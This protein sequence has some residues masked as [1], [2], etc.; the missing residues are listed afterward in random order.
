MDSSPGANSV[1]AN[2]SAFTSVPAEQKNLRAQTL[3]ADHYI[4]LLKKLT[5]SHPDLA[6]ILFGGPEEIAGAR[7]NRG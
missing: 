4:A 5:A 3:A 1:L 7:T 6:V 2:G